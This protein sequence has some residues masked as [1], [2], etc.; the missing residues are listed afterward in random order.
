MDPVVFAVAISAVAL[1]EP[2]TRWRAGAAA[3]IVGGVVLLRL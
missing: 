2:P 1:R 3:V